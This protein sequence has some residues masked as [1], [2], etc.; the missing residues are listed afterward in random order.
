LEIHKLEAVNPLCPQLYQQKSAFSFTIRS[1][2]KD[3]DTD[4]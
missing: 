3:G 4:P 2:G 1:F